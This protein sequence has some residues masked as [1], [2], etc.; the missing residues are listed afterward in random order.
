M[1]IP[2]TVV[3]IAFWLATTA[4]HGAVDVQ[5]PASV[6]DS[7]TLR[8]QDTEMRPWGLEASTDEWCSTPKGRYGERAEKAVEHKGLRATRRSR[9][10]SVAAGA[11]LPRGRRASSAHGYIP[12]ESSRNVAR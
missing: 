11:V 3:A 10:T 2:A 7:N 5:G 12:S 8:V 1:R 6:I 4:V 9:P